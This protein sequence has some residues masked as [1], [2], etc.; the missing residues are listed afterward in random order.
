MLFS[1]YEYST[2]SNLHST[3]LVLHFCGSWGGDIEFL[4]DGDDIGSKWDKVFIMVPG[5]GLLYEYLSGFGC[6]LC[7]VGTLTSG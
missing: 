1:R 3:S 2:L 7:R 6:R 5:R 4:I